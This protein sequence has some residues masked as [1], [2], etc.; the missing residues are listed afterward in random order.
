MEAPTA[1]PIARYCSKAQQQSNSDRAGC[2]ASEHNSTQ[3]WHSFHHCRFC[4]GSR[5]MQAFIMSADGTSDTV[6]ARAT[7]SLYKRAISQ[8]HVLLLHLGAPLASAAIGVNCTKHDAATPRK[9]GPLNS[10]EEEGQAT[11]MSRLGQINNKQ[12]AHA[13]QMQSTI[14]YLRP[15]RRQV[16]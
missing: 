3:Q 12:N 11:P 16:S 1:V 8:R 14:A 4:T 6:T 7:V 2:G 5:L 9:G 15:I 13:A 10:A